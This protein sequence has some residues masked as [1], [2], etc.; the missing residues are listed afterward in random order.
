[1]KAEVG[2]DEC[3]YELIIAFLGDASRRYGSGQMARL[4]AGAAVNGAAST[5]ANPLRYFLPVLAGEGGSQDLSLEHII[6]MRSASA[7]GHMHCAR[8]DICGV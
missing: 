1:M 7:A 3:D 6:Q 8:F 2:L 4:L 5:Q